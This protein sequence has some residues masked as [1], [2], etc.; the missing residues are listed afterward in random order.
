MSLM[1][2]YLGQLSSKIEYRAHV[3]LSYIEPFV[4]SDTLAIL[5]DIASLNELASD[6]ISQLSILLVNFNSFFAMQPQPVFDSIVFGVFIL[7]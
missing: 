1:R 6:G 3:S 7:K 4:L 5:Y 2:F